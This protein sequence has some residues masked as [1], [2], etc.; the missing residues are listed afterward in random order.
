MFQTSLQSKRAIGL[1]ILFIFSSTVFAEHPEP[2]LT[3]N[4]SPFSIIYGLPLASSAHL[5]QNNQSRWIS[6]FN[7]SNTIN[8]QT[9]NNEE[10]F[11]DVET[12]HVNFLYDYAFQEN[13]MLRVQLPYIVHSAGFLDSAIENYHQ[14][15]SLPDGIGPDFPHDQI[16]INASQN[17]TPL[18]S[19]NS[20]QNS[21]GDISIQLAWQAQQ[22]EQAAL[23]YWLSLKLPTGNEDKLT[24]SGGT[25]L[26][27][28]A[29]TDYRLSNTRWVYGQAGL[30]FMSDSSI[31]NNT[32]NNWAVFGNAG[33]KFQP[34]KDIELK[35]QF[36]IHSA[37][38]DSDLEFLSHV[39]QLTFGGSYTI[40][41]KHKL[42]FSVA[43]DIKIEASPDVNFNI[44]WWVYL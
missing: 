3:R 43:E 9:S 30:L 33:I 29:S 1:A 22:S 40:N 23:S 38:Y 7:V 12:W 25:D 20:K 15:L 28:W 34:W 4:E 41:K 21:L 31:L 2:F 19:I 26:A 37:F 32:Q 10:L 16:S 36:D 6:S 11:I 13:W 8:S 42:D 27:I 24:G 17:N 5:L 44:S 35:A 18:V 39:I 14:A